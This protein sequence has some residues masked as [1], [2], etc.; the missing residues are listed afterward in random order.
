MTHQLRTKLSKTVKDH[1]VNT[2][3][4]NIGNDTTKLKKHIA[5]FIER[6]AKG[7]TLA[8]KPSSDAEFESGGKYAC[9]IL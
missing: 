5:L 9:I 1:N 2:D 7:A 4:I 3:M 6:L 8:E